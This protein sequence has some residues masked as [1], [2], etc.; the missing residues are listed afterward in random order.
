MTSKQQL[1]AL[2][3]VKARFYRSVSIVAD[4]EDPGAL[5]DYIVSP[6]SRA[7][8]RRISKGLQP[9]S[10]NRAWS[11]VG[12][13][14]SG[15]SAFA[16]FLSRLL[17]SPGDLEARRSLQLCDPE[18]FEEIGRDVS[19]WDKRGLVV[20]PIVGG[21]QP[22][23]PAVLNALIEALTRQE[24][25]R[26]D[27]KAFLASLRALHERAH[28]G[29]PLEVKDLTESI[30]RATTLV[31][32]GKRGALGLLV[33]I[34][35]LGKFLEYA[36]LNPLDGDIFLL[37]ALAELASRSG[38]EPFGLLVVSH[39]SFERYAARLSPLQQREWAKIQ[40]RF[41][42]IGFL[43]SSGEL[44]HLLGTAVEPAENLDGLTQIIATEVGRVR[45]LDLAPRDLNPADADTALIHCAPLHPTV[46]LVLGR[47]FRSRL[48]QNERSLFAFL[49][50]GEPYGFQEF[51]GREIWAGNGNRP[52]YRLDQ[53]YEY[54]LAAMGS[55]L[56][57]LSQGKRWAEID[58][59]LERL[60]KDSRHLDAQVVK[61]IGLLGL[62]G[63]QRQLRASEDVLIYALADGKTVS[64]EDVRDSLRRLCAWKVAI[65]REHK[66]AYWLW[67]GSDVDLDERLQRGLD[68]VERSASLAE[69]LTAHSRL[70]PYLA[71]R[72]LH[73]TGTLR[74][75]VPWIVDAKGLT[76]VVDRPFGAADGAIVFVLQDNGTS[77]E[78][79]RDAVLAVSQDLS[80]P[81]K[82]LMLFATPVETAGIRQAL[83]EVSAWK[84]VGDNTPELEG[85]S[86]ARKELAGRQLE[87]E[88]RLGR[89]CASCFDQSSS[90]HSAHWTYRG[91]SCQFS[92]SAELS[93]RLSN[94][95]DHVYH[96]API[97]KNE[98]VN[99][100]SLSSSAAAARRSLLER[101]VSSSGVRALGIDTGFPP[102]LSMYRSVF[103]ASGLHHQGASGWEF[104]LGD[105]D[106]HRQ[107]ANL[108]KGIDHFLES[109]ERVKRSVAD[110]YDTL[111]QPPYGLKD[112]L[113]PLYVV[114]ALKHW[115][116][117][118]ALY[119]NGSFVPKVDIAVVERLVRNPALFL[120]QRYRLG[121]ARGY[122][123][124]QYAAL[125]RRGEAARDS[126]TLLAAVRPLL[127]FVQ[128][129]PLYSQRTSTV[130]A[131]AAKVR[132]A[133]LSAKEP[134]RLLFEDLPRAMAMDPI[135][136]DGAMET[137]QTFF[138]A[139][140]R[141]LLE[142][143][144]T[145]DG[146]IGK[147]QEQLADEMRLPAGLD[148]AR[149]ELRQRGLLL[150]DHVADLRLKAVLMRLCDARL[151][152][153]E[154]L[155]S[156]ASTLVGRPPR[157]WGDRDL[158]VYGTSLAEAAG[159]L[160]RVEEI[161]LDRKEGATFY[162]GA[163]R[164]RLAITEESGREA[165]DIVTIQLEEEAQV[166][167]MADA[168][169]REIQREGASSHL[170][171]AAVAELAR[172][173][174]FHG[175]QGNLDGNR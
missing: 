100:R 115:E 57:G 66:S 126:S 110:L 172:R 92:S 41:E 95:C 17:G 28:L 84:W 78:Q 153:R 3:R 52:F 168:L 169:Q 108:W 50:S 93:A 155:E 117:E 56:Y 15:K 26:P 133:I 121:Q 112:G 132:D 142:L 102:D 109:T 23:G 105:S 113:I 150:Q 107:V 14:G 12:P 81:R 48:A 158:L 33:I 62:L 156:L 148:Q 162:E 6:L 129:L 63:D 43:E 164:V 134:H 87:A 152:D 125:L 77:L 98:L 27:Q 34:D 94:A 42:D 146:L 173:M 75:F 149:N 72:H 16:L 25:D 106:V 10:R 85:D 73:Q 74:Y 170:A 32:A 90:Y 1:S 171:T 166:R 76:Q 128:Q 144:R 21:R 89:L 165:R 24:L 60:P 29:K 47:L 123:L 130:S 45:E 103:E 19:N 174:L 97:V 118:T 80:S 83:E 58:D 136:D 11:L 124:E 145:Y 143:Q 67:E 161:L 20:V 88:T 68:Q 111:R 91:E 38:R 44:L 55:T 54:V 99:R 137:A 7:V 147:V 37:Q 131:E 39:Q 69:L 157:Q 51:L 141:A 116:A 151:A 135:Q 159:Q 5:A 96:A 175:K 71:K 53:L 13:Y 167:A 79:V 59:A 61:S 2:F 154:W 35:E 163:R 101:M 22:L 18:L 114:A 160:R 82:E 49:T 31:R 138:A 119:E 4:Y 127:T 122:L 8:L 70:K 64:A 36:A 120:L 46:S 30:A 40:G 140:K 139:L 9:G 65:F 86:I 104:G